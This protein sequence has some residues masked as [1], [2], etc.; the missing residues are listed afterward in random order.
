VFQLGA[1]GYLMK[2]FTATELVHHVEFHCGRQEQVRVTEPETA[3]A[4]LQVTAAS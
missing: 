4:C 3:D 1:C 2:P